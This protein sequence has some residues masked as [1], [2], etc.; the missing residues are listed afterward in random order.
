M[1]WIVYEKKYNY[2]VYYWW[3]EI[4]YFDEI[5]GIEVYEIIWL[6]CCY[7]KWFMCIVWVERNVFLEWL[8][9]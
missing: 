4:C 6:C 9:G 8:I 3:I 5:K 1:I 7:L 2:L